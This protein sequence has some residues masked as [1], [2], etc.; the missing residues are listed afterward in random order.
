MLLLGVGHDANTTIHPD[1][2]ETDCADPTDYNCDGS[3]GAADNDLDGASACEDCDDADPTRSP[4]APEVCDE[5]G[6]DED[7]DTLVNDADPS[8]DPSTGIG[9]Y[10]DADGDGQGDIAGHRAGLRDGDRVC[11]ERLRLR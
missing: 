11:R 9:L 2:P 6:R 4:G 1:A 10:P 5:L 3:V 7:C 8:R